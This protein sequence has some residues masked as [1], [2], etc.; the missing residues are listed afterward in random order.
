M[1]AIDRHCR[2]FFVGGAIGRAEEF[3]VDFRFVYLHLR[4]GRGRS[5]AVR[6]QAGKKLDEITKARFAALLATRPVDVMLQMDEGPRFLKPGT[7]SS[8][9]CSP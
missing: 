6:L 2:L 7:F 3:S 1:P 8:T 5:A 4:M 9:P